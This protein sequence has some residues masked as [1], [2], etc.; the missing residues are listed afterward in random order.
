[1]MQYDKNTRI[2][3]LICLFLVMM[4]QPVQARFVLPDYL[5]VE[6]LAAN[7]EAYIA[8]HPNEPQ[9]Y[10][11]LGRIHYLA[12]ISRIG[13]VGAYGSE[14]LPRLVGVG[15]EFPFAEA[16][17]NDAR[18]TEAQARVLQAWG[19]SDVTE[20]SP[21]KLQAYYDAVRAQQQALAQQGWQ[22][23][24]LTTAAL[25]SHA[26]SAIEHFERAMDLDPD[27]GLYYLGAASL[28]EQFSDFVHDANITDVP[29]PLAHTPTPRIRLTY[30]LAYRL[31]VEEDLTWGY[32]PLRGL[33]SLVAYEAGQAYLRLAQEEPSIV[34]VNAVSWVQ[35][36]LAVLDALPYRVITPIVFT[37]QPHTSVLDLLQPERTVSFD[38]D[39]D[40][41]IESWPWV[42]PTTGLLVWDPLGRGEITSGRQLF[43][44]ASWQLLFGNGYE[45]LKLLDDNRDG[46]LAGVELDG[47]GVWFD[48]NSNGRSEPGE[49]S[50]VERLGIRSIDTRV[51]GADSGMPMSRQGLRFQDGHS[52]STYDWTVQ[53]VTRDP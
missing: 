53:S 29:I 24:S 12:F 47:I 14:G 10:Y 21:D 43:G 26:E 41:R 1:M 38:L 40:G 49:V 13:L 11:T 48:R 44:S 42:K 22:P 35:R 5:P 33:R 17:L 7:T 32:I 23:E 18:R 36:D 9:G 4:V 3:F 46:V 8:E 16:V 25:V 51:T 31:A 19:L 52:V 15:E 34:D 50:S 30:Y 27:N 20:V 6:R 45:A 39:G 28:Y 2:P 37:E